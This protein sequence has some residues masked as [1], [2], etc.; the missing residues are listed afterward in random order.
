M[1]KIEIEQS[2]KSFSNGHA[3]LDFVGNLIN[4]AASLREHLERQVPGP[5]MISHADVFKTYL[6]LLCPGRMALKPLRR[7]PAMTVSK[8]LCTFRRFLHMK[9]C[10]NLLT[11]TLGFSNALP[12]LVA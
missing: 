4:V 11:S 6:G 9:P 10:N 12:T 2:L 3:G 1:K 7:W 5:S 8:S